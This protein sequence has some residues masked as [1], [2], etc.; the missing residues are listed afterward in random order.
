M[1]DLIALSGGDQLG[2]TTMLD[3]I[4]EVLAA[5]ATTLAIPCDRLDPAFFDLRTGV[6]GE[7]LQKFVNYRIR[8]VIVGRLPSSATSS[9]AFAALMRE[10]NRGTQVRFIESIDRLKEGQPEP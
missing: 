3:V 2:S 7:I 4:A 9:A 6:A 8:L 1:P 5:G 10:S